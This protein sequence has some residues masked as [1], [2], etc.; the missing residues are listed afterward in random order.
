ME[1]FFHGA[2]A[3]IPAVIALLS[4]RG[5]YHLFQLESYQFPGYFRA[6]RRNPVQAW[7]PGLCSAA[8]SFILLFSFRRL[9]G[10]I[11]S[12]VL[13][14]IVLMAFL[15]L[16][17]AAGLLIARILKVKTP[18]KPFVFTNRVKRLYAVTAIIL[19]V[20]S[21]L[22]GTLETVIAVS[23]W[24]AILPL[25]IAACGFIAWGPEKMI[26]EYY[27]RSARKKLLAQKDLIRVGITG[28]YGKTTVKHILGTLLSQKYPVLITPKSFNTPMGV[29]RTIRER[30]LPSHQVF[31][32]EMGARHAGDI[33]EL[34]RLVKPTVGILTSIGPQHLE[35]FKTIGRVA[36]TKY[37]LIAAL[38]EDGQCF[39]ADDHAICRQLFEQT[40]KQKTLVSLTAKD[41][42]VWSENISVSDE[43]SAFDLCFVSGERLRCQTCLLGEHNVINILTAAAVADKLGLTKSQIMRGVRR[44]EPVPG[45]LELLK[46]PNSYTIINDG[47]NANPV[48][49]QAALN[50]LRQFPKRRIIVTPGM[51]EL[52]AK[53]AEYNKAFG[54]AIAMAADIAIIIGKK[55]VQPILDGLREAGF[56]GGNIHQV[57]S[58]RESTAVLQQ[59]V[60]KDDTVLYENDLPDN[61]QEH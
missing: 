35:T 52:G 22:L 25:L 39:F 6:I 47:F 44:I 30:L 56:P 42:G 19:G 21:Y 20:A 10:A 58:L 55:R 59:L 40:E 23:A 36:K 49:A 5:I 4:A 34:C 32:A 46:N 61:Y 16:A 1:E 43:G 24:P 57:G 41:A 7:T 28:S 13:K 45:R 11:Q 31:I 15:A 12:V 53:E 50:V 8:A 17:V 27:F 14:A 18:K 60:R 37:E 3:F 38:P 29:A 54:K 26:S 2:G 51:V 9:N 48:G 33:R